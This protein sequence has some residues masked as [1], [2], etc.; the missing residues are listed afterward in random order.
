MCCIKSLKRRNR[1]ASAGKMKSRELNRLPTVLLANYL[2]CRKTIIAFASSKL[3]MPCWLIECASHMGWWRIR[4]MRSLEESQNL[5]ITSK[6]L[7]HRTY[8]KMLKMPTLYLS[9][10]PRS[11]KISLR[12]WDILVSSSGHCLM[13]LSINWGMCLRETVM[14]EAASLS[15]TSISCTTFL[16]MV[17]VMHQ[18]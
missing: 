17:R 3:T 16:T 11:L 13:R 7:A 18:I 8:P 6:R 5:D 12:P 10:F 2:T 1:H 4:S 9:R 14:V 15:K